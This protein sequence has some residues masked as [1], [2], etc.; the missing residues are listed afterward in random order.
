MWNY[1][2]NMRENHDCDLPMAYMAQGYNNGV[3]SAL[4]LH[5]VQL[6]KL[7]CCFGGCCMQLVCVKHQWE[8]C[9]KPFFVIWCL[10]VVSSIP[11]RSTIIYRFLCGFMCISLS[12][13]IKIKSTNIYIYICGILYCSSQ[14][15]GCIGCICVMMESVVCGLSLSNVI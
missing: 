2:S 1:V 4:R 15:S 8:P 12:Q 14:L 13:S 3:Y 6:G 9:C 7:W 11:D 5:T 10:E